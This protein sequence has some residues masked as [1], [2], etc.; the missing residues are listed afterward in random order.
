[1]FQHHQQQRYPQRITLAGHQSRHT[2]TARVQS[3][4][5][6]NKLASS[7]PP[8]TLPHGSTNNGAAAILGH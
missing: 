5:P 6:E 4:M 8:V 1:M 2:T 3:P 7:S